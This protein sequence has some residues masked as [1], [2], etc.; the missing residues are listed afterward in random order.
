M[1]YFC[2]M[3][4]THVDFTIEVPHSLQRKMLTGNTDIGN[5]LWYFQLCHM[6]TKLE[7]IA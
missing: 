4:G 2:L 6:Q 5:N 1:G 7:E 3:L